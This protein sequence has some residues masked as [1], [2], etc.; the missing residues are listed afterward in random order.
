MYDS[1]RELQNV[2]LCDLLCEGGH[3]AE[4]ACPVSAGENTR[5]A[6]KG[7]GTKTTGETATCQHTVYCV[8]EREFYFNT[9]WCVVIL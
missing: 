7:Q 6:F 8:A 2:R 5:E 3:V 1:N 4:S 9:M